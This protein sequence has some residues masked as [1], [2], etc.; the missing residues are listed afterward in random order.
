MSLKTFLLVQTDNVYYMKHLRRLGSAQRGSSCPCSHC[1]AQTC[2]RCSQGHS[3]WHGNS[4]NFR[5]LLDSTLSRRMAKPQFSI[6]GL[7]YRTG[8]VFM[9]RHG[10]YMP[11]QH[12]SP[13]IVGAQAWRHTPNLN[14]KLL[15]YLSIDLSINT[16]KITLRI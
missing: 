11:A 7:V 14:F 16:S 6:T 15:Y 3:I 9:A 10:I 13:P 4:L 2:S 1:D 5:N 12:A 8:W